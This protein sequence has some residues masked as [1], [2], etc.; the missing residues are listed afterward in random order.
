M[1]LPVLNLK[2]KLIALMVLLL[3]L[4]LSA[5]VFV[6]VKAQDAIVR[7]TQ[8]KVQDLA[9]VSLNPKLIGAALNPGTV[10]AVLALRNAPG[11]PGAV[12]GSKVGLSDRRSTV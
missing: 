1:R 3:G 11:E 7:T 10:R 6:S 9:S 8:R 12:P 5:E 2:A 4:T